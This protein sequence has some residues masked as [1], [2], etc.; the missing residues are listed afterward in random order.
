MD[1]IRHDGNRIQHAEKKLIVFHCIDVVDRYDSVDPPAPNELTWKD[2]DLANIMGA[3]SPRHFWN[4]LVGK[5]LAG[6]PCERDLI[7]MPEQEWKLCQQGVKESLQKFLNNPGISC[8]VLT[9]A[10]HR[11][12][13]AFLPVCDSVIINDV[14]SGSNH[15]RAETILRIMQV[16]RKVGMSNLANLQHI[17]EFLVKQSGLRDLTNIRMLEALYWMENTPRYKN[18]WSCMKRF[19]WWC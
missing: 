17:R 12:R 1:I 5:S 7:T 8:S 3:R 16:F 11:K 9:K 14:L 10:L 13:P 2:V 15:K 4:D 19:G 6:I 18:L